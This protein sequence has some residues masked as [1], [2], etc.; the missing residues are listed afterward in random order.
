ML[1][2]DLL[3]PESSP[4]NNVGK[5]RE[6]KEKYTAII[7]ERLHDSGIIVC[8]HIIHQ[9]DLESQCESKREHNNKTSLNPPNNLSTIIKR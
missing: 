7:D 8:V 5:I 9:I 6:S 3:R 4:H 1:A 2:K